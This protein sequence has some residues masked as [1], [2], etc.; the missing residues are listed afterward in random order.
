M[1]KFSKD[2][3]KDLLEKIS[4]NR[5][6]RLELMSEA[7]HKCGVE[8]AERFIDKALPQ[9]KLFMT[10]VLPVLH[11]LYLPEPSG[12]T[13]TVLDV[14]PQNFA[15][16]E[17]L[18]SIHSK[19]SF[20]RLKLEVT[21]L[22]ITD[23]FALFKEVISPDTEFLVK[24]IYDIHDRSWDAIIC[25]HVIEHVPEPE[26]FVRRLQELSN[27][28]VIIG[29][30]WSEDPLVTRTHINT[31]K[32]DFINKVGGRDLEIFT[33]YS[34]GKDREVCLFWLPGLAKQQ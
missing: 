21:A 15:G 10:E 25:S 31:I 28:Y 20:N 3:H 17:L 6:E 7:L 23:A 5:L 18:S 19:K 24:N 12:I 22:D 16:T 8:D 29:C 9:S 1:T 26:K 2:D 14:G 30:P 34:W 11:R 27:D 4:A 33:N 32:R 13:K